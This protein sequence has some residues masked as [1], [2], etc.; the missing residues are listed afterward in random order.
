[1]DTSNSCLSSDVISAT[2]KY[3]VLPK[4]EFFQG[5]QIELTRNSPRYNDYYYF[6]D[7]RLY[8]GPNWTLSSGEETVTLVVPGNTQIGKILFK[9]G[10]DENT[11]FNKNGNTDSI[12]I[13]RN[14]A[15]FTLSNSTITSGNLL[16]VTI[17]GDPT[18]KS[19]SCY[20]TNYN[21]KIGQTE[22]TFSPKYFD[23]NGTTIANVTIPTSFSPK[24]DNEVT[25][26]ISGN[27]FT[28]ETDKVILS[29]EVGSN[30][31]RVN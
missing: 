28:D 9:V 23:P 3:Y 19:I 12:T 17:S 2:S 16:T 6:G 15:I 29:P 25:L 31:L 26:K 20:C 24:G 21:L 7:T 5:E 30:K 4:F 10:N 22:F 13:K 11:A 18:I 14:P 27:K 1:S 8:G